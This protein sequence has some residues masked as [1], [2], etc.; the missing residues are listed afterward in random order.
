MMMSK[1]GREQ[2]MSNMNGDR[3]MTMIA[4]AISLNVVRADDDDPVDTIRK[5]TSQK[6][7]KKM[8]RR[9]REEAEEDDGLSGMANKLAS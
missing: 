9:R 1:Q 7:K 8:K 4:R 6:K 5:K 2:E 3:T